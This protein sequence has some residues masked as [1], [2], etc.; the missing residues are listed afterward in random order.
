MSETG[1]HGTV[2]SK[3]TEPNWIG[4]CINSVSAFPDH[5][6]TGDVVSSMQDLQFWVHNPCSLLSVQA[7]KG[8]L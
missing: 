3:A 6:G 5:L 4:P 2:R 1:E 7:D 8:I